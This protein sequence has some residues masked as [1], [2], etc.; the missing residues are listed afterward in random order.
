MKDFNFFGK[1]NSVVKY[2]LVIMALFY[3]TPSSSAAIEGTWVE[4]DNKVYGAKPDARGPIGGGEGYTEI[5]TTGDYIV[6]KGTTVSELKTIIENAKAGEVVF[7]EGDVVISGTDLQDIQ[8]GNGVT[9]ASDRGRNGSLGALLINPFNGADIQREVFHVVGS[10]VRITGLRLEGL[11]HDDGSNH[12]TAEADWK[13]MTMAIR[14]EGDSLEVDNC[15][16]Y[17][18][19]WAA[20]NLWTGADHYIHHN[21]IHHNWRWGYGYGVAIHYAS[22]IIEYNYFNYQ[23][24][25]IA[26][27]GMLTWL[28]SYPVP[29]E[30]I[31]RHNVQGDYTTHHSF[32]MHGYDNEKHRPLDGDEEEKPGAIAGQKM[33]IYNNTF[34]NEHV[35]WYNE[36][37]GMPDEERII[38][39]DVK[40]RGRSE[41]LSKVYQNWFTIHPTESR[42][43]ATTV[44]DPNNNNLETFDN[45]YGNGYTTGGQEEQPQ[46]V[47]DPN[48]FIIDPITKTLR[49]K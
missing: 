40:I 36:W 27:D 35:S 24:H 39:P 9:V 31:A 2:F 1:N 6:K 26:G 11:E 21:N 18:W 16:M 3:I 10:N 38:S 13:G 17:G 14:C 12:D 15:E 28:P 29:C 32:D 47:V 42:A 22:A 43:V 34:Q 44:V 19:Q 48:T 33:T 37:E 25:S 7:L 46:E 23:A 20:I 41:E 45:I 4:I 8:L 5:I 49:I 30:F